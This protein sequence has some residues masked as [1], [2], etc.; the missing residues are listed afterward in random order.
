[1]KLNNGFELISAPNK[2]AKSIN[3]G[4]YFYGGSAGERIYES[5][6]H[7]LLEHMFFRRLSDMSQPKLYSALN[8]IGTTMRGA[9][10]LNFLRFDITVSP[11][12]L[13]AAL[14]IILKFF[15]EFS[16]SEQEVQSEQEVVLNQIYF[17]GGNSFYQNVQKEYLSR[18][19]F[20]QPI[21]GN[22]SSV[23]RISAERLNQL[24]KEIVSPQNAV[25]VVTG[26]VSEE[27]CEYI[28]RSLSS[29]EK[30]AGSIKE[31]ICTLPGTFLKRSDR[32]IDI[33]SADD[34]IS[35]IIFS[36]DIP[37]RQK[38]NLLCSLVLQ[39]FAAGD[40]AILPMVLR[41]ELHYTDEVYF[42]FEEY[43]SFSRG[44]LS[45]FVR[46][47]NTLLSINKTFETMANFVADNS[48][49]AFF[50]T[51]PFLLD[52]AD[53]SCDDVRKYNLEIAFKKMI[54]NFEEDFIEQEKEILKSITP[55]DFNLAKKELFV[56]SRMCVS[57]QCPSSLKKSTLKKEIKK[58]LKKLH[59]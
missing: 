2:S 58:G 13:K 5:G 54:Y 12:H 16:W 25:V 51:I 57:V 38:E 43:P 56:P 23:K 49:D 22:E 59:G 39:A 6:I 14:N 33:F 19:G 4:L 35:E 15:S 7:H 48:D 37:G 34:D 10:Y 52:N 20:E 31:P 50:E 17:S 27:N 45:F 8:R 28:T 32:S 36:F 24:K 41:E 30:T 46:E 1:M 21:M 47:E 42:S 44:C 11:K 40:G 9:T 29:I 18:T 55:L 26:N 53:F 3:I